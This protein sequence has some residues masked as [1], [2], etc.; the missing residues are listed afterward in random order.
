[1]VYLAGKDANNKTI[2]LE[3]DGSPHVHKTK[4]EQKQQHQETLSSSPTVEHIHNL[5]ASMDG[6]LDR[7]LN[8]ADRK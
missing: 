8:L 5:L 4:E 3:E 2:Y 1:M 7:L 6:K